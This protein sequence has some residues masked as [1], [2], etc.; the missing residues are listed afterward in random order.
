[1][2][3]RPS[4]GPRS[5]AWSLRRGV[6]RGSRVGAGLS[7][8]LLVVS[9]LS[10]NA[11]TAGITVPEGADRPA[12]GPPSHAFGPDGV[13]RGPIPRAAFG[14]LPARGPAAFGGDRIYDI[15]VE[16]EGQRKSYRVHEFTTPGTATFTVT[17][18]NLTVDY[19]VV[20][21]GGGG[22]NAWQGWGGGGGGA[23]GLRQ[24]TTVL[25]SAGPLDVVIGSGGAGG[26]AEGR[27]GASDGATG[28]DSRLGNIIADGG[29]GGGGS[30]RFG[31]AGGS[32]GG[33]G[34][35]HIQERL[36]GQPAE[37]QGHKG[38]DHQANV[39]LAGGGGGAGGA[40]QTGDGGPS[41]PSA[42]TGAPREYA[43]GGSG[44]T[45][46]ESRSG[47]DGDVRPGDGGGGASSAWSEQ[48]G[49]NGG[50]GIVIVRYEIP[51]AIWA[52]VSGIE[53][54]STT[55]VI[56]DGLRYREHRFTS[57]GSR[58]FDV[59]TPVSGAQLEVLV[60]GGGGGGGSDAGGGGG[61]GALIEGRLTFSEAGERK[62]TVAVGQGG[63][64]GL[65]SSG[66][67]FS[68]AGGHSSIL[69][70]RSGV[71]EFSAAA[72]GGR[73][74]A[75]N[76][77][78]A[79]NVNGGANT[80]AG[81]TAPSAPTLNGANWSA[82]NARP[83][84]AGGAPPGS[85]YEVKGDGKPGVGGGDSTLFDGSY[86]GGA[87]SGSSERVVT[88][89]GVNGGG[90]GSGASDPLNCALRA[91]A[92]APNSGGGGG[93]GA[94]YGS[95][96]TTCTGNLNTRDGE[97]GGSGI[98]IVRYP[99]DRLVTDLPS[100]V[101]DVVAGEGAASAVLR[102]QVPE[103]DAPTADLEGYRIEYSPLAGGEWE[104]ID[105]ANDIEFTTSGDEITVALTG[106]TDVT[107]H[108][109]RITPLGSVDGPSTT[110]TPIA[111]GGD[112]V[113]LV[114]DDVV[115]SYTTV[116]SANFDLG[117]TRQVNYLVVG[118]G[119]GGGF[120]N[121]N[122]GGGGGGAGG[123]LTNV[124]GSSLAVESDSRLTVTVGQGGLGG[125][126]EEIAGLNGGPSSIDGTALQPAVVAAGGGGGGSC[127]TNGSAGASGGGGSG[128]NFS[129]PGGGGIPGQGNVG[130][131]GTH[132]SAA[133]Q[134]NGG[135]GG[136]AGG[137]GQ[138]G[139]ARAA[140]TTGGAGAGRT[141]AITGVSNEYSRGGD[142][143][144]GKGNGTG[145]QGTDGR[146]NGGGGSAQQ[147]GARGGNGI[148]VIR[149]S[150][151]DSGVRGGVFA[152][153]ATTAVLRFEE[154]ELG[155]DT[156]TGYR[157]ER[158]TDGVAWT[159]VNA[160]PTASGPVRTLSLTGLPSASARRFRVTALHGERTGSVTEIDVVGRGGD[161][162]ALVG[163]DVVHT[164]TTVTSVAVAGSGD[165]TGGVTCA[166]TGVEHTLLL[167]AARNVQHLIVAGG[168]GGGSDNAGGG[169]GGGVLSAT[170]LRA[171]GPST[172][173]V[174]GGGLA[175]GINNANLQTNGCDSEIFGLKAFGGG[176]GGNG[177]PGARAA[178]EGGSGGGGHGERFSGD[179]PPTTGGAGTAG[180]P[181]QGFSGG[182]GLI[183]PSNN[184]QGE[185]GGGGGAGEPGK[186]AEPQ[187]P[188]DGGIGLASDITGAPYYYGSGGGGGTHRSTSGFRRSGAGGTSAGGGGGGALGDVDAS[189]GEDGFGGGGGGSATTF[190]SGGSG[191]SGI[192]IVRYPFAP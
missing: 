186:N 14:E 171:A 72:T 158:S 120:G 90:R 43:A 71:T 134:G 175:S 1:V 32:G 59:S 159:T 29:G 121:S 104:K 122:E 98:V 133:Q 109:F 105:D 25:A 150:F 48:S 149:Y 81:G 170:V 37:G 106:L 157:I 168:G 156:I 183:H 131:A 97:P 96:A 126:S 102:W 27:D 187:E 110:V 86:G 165:D 21:G 92:G 87:G 118:G 82:Q 113:T 83:G 154:P 68:G 139:A 188:G 75:R 172:V 69:V 141:V 190:T 33:A 148:V 119:G 93:A 114:G 145:A 142:G 77:R 163:D 18:P 143:F 166:A 34:G 176:Q 58:N 164:F 61:G 24:G 70:S 111:K 174:G 124:D 162:V 47:P 84:G 123:L 125:T 45:R 115:H 22:G 57:T 31:L 40:G 67:A 62:M 182:N 127:R 135:G 46:A 51:R 12:I 52:P 49:G 55:E 26:P 155:T 4:V 178:T 140:E 116:G 74:G 5:H 7:A 189:H 107:R 146:G 181:R 54:D 13:G 180:P 85:G 42:I 76:D 60:V 73:G 65:W 177:Q 129:R 9:A 28:G 138:G 185:G 147:A 8:L 15:D 53:G 79:T 99:L 63:S 23:G 64:R 167:G 16:V 94:A 169:G 136:G 101:R 6:R 2:R 184:G 160:A 192:V 11:I 38:G 95:S 161:T 78:N 44:G 41:L 88:A 10:V 36:G 20:A 3:R 173:V 50:S 112:T 80:G 91:T 152:E 128:C 144:R 66:G 100:G 117:Q 56:I 151:R 179:D 19:L 191:G 132:V 153:A 30:R 103:F 89:E 35:R 17:R 137:A 39:E 130:G 108:R